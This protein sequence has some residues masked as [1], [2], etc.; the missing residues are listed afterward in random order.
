MCYLLRASRWAKGSGRCPEAASTDAPAPPAA[1]A[2][3]GGDGAPEAEAPPDARRAALMTNYDRAKRGTS[4][5]DSEKWVWGKIKQGRQPAPVYAEGLAQ[6]SRR[7]A[8]LRARS[9]RPRVGGRK[10]RRQRRRGSERKM[11]AQPAPHGW[12]GGQRERE[13]KVRAPRRGWVGA[14]AAFPRAGSSVLG[15]QSERRARSDAAATQRGHPKGANGSVISRVCA[16]PQRGA[17]INIISCYDNIAGPA[18]YLS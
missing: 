16:A 17:L 8:G 2:G 6:T 5:H 14:G 7:S 1:A 13:R 3:S 18:R 12:R 11:R 4:A 15:Y 10:P 9:A